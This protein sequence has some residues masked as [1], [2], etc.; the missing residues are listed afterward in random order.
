MEVVGRGVLVL[1]GGGGGGGGIG[2]E[3][4]GYWICCPLTLMST[5]MS[6]LNLR[7]EST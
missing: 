1:G 5:L 3:L 2:V 7:P 4:G 6:R